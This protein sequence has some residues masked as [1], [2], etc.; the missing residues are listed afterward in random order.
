[1]LLFVMYAR[2]ARSTKIGL[3]S[4]HSELELGALSR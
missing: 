1:M 3:V 4:S 2:R